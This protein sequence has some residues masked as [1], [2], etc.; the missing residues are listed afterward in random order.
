M[1]FSRGGF[2]F[3]SAYGGSPREG[4]LVP[5]IHPQFSD[6][7][8]SCILDGEMLVWNDVEKRVIVKAEAPDV[9]KLKPGGRIRPMFVPFDLVFLNGDVLTERPLCERLEKLKCVFRPLEGRLD[10]TTRLEAS[11]TEEV[12]VMAS[13]R[14]DKLRL[15]WAAFF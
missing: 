11:T 3:T 14:C 5:H 13:F 9:K 12:R 10:V 1:F 15:E 7:V 2:D 8:R 6:T 4:A